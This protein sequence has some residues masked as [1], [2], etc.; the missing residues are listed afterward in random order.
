[1]MKH[2][3]IKELVKETANDTHHQNGAHP[4]PQKGWKATACYEKTKFTNSS[5]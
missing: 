4:K 3:S 1:M 2:P 5:G